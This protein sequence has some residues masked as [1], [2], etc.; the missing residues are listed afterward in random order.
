MGYDGGS[1]S[2]HQI[3]INGINYKKNELNVLTEDCKSED[4]HLI[5]I[6]DTK[7]TNSKRLKINGYKTI[8]K[9]SN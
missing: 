9:D 7:L 2:I 3:N 1:V 4:G 8:R 5:L 6:N